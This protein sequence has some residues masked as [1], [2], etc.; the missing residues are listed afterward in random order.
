ML[1]HRMD[2]DRLALDRALVGE[3]LEPSHQLHD[4]VG[5]V[6]DEPRQRAVVIAGGLLQAAAPHRGCPRADS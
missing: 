3:H 4:A 2:V 6:A 5:L 1:Q